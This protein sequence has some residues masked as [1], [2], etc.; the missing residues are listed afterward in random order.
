MN[1][2]QIIGIVVKL[3]FLWLSTKAE[4]DKELKIR[5]ENATKEISEGIKEKDMSKVTA[6]FDRINR[7]R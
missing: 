3:V 2:I 4:K 5:K 6:A 7:L 1:I